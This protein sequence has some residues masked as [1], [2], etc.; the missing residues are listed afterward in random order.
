[1]AR[2][3]LA[4]VLL[5]SR[6]NPKLALSFHMFLQG[7]GSIGRG[8]SNEAGC[9]CNRIRKVK[10]KARF[11]FSFPKLALVRPILPKKKAES[12]RRPP[13]R[14]AADAKAKA[15]ATAKAKAKAAARS[16]EEGEA[17]PANKRAKRG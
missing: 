13:R 17:G 1:M 7:C 5:A 9:P 15:K 4:E 14:K 3:R 11:F 10:R 16:A 2:T 8:I 12:S 6:T